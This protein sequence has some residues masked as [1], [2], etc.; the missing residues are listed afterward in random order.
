MYKGILHL[1][2]YFII[3]ETSHTSLEKNKITTVY[4]YTV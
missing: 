3:I 1:L 2:P 4:V